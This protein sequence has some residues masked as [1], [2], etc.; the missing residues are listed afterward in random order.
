[1]SRNF[2]ALGEKVSER[3]QVVMLDLA[4]GSETFGGKPGKCGLRWASNIRGVY[5]AEPSVLAGGVHRICA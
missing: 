1:M 2:A 5:V 4:S 3:K